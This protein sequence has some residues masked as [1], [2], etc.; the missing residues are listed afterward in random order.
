MNK[1]CNSKG[2][3]GGGVDRAELVRDGE[4][5]Q[6]LPW[7]R[8]LVEAGQVQDCDHGDVSHQQLHERSV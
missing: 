1:Y 6:Q 8:N 5:L 2:P 7:Q 3:V 4:G